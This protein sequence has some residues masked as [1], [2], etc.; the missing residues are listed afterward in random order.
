MPPFAWIT[1][2]TNPTEFS[3]F[4]VMVPAS[5]EH[6]AAFRGALLLLQFVSN[7]EQVGSETPEDCAAL[8]SDANAQTFVMEECAQGVLMMPIGTIFWWPTEAP[9]E[10]TRICDGQSYFTSRFPALFDL[11]GYTF[12]GTGGSFNL[13][14]LINKF[15]YGYGSGINVADTGGEAE[16][17]L[18]EDEM[19]AHDHTYPKH[20]ASGVAFTGLGTI[21]TIGTQQASSVTGGDQPHNN[22]PPYLALVPC[23]VCEIP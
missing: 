6:E 9:P 2:E 20:T 18:T 4:R 22:L 11:I 8:W 14:D 15:A 10:G 16:H 7:W 3:C 17:T 23:I 19:P 1:P 21:Q 5:I 12:G 13:P